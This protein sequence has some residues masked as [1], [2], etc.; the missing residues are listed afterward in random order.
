MNSVPPIREGLFQLLYSVIET[1]VCRV[2]TSKSRQSLESLKTTYVEN[3]PEYHQLVF[4]SGR[5]QN[6][7]D[8]TNALVKSGV[9]QFSAIE[10][11]QQFI[12]NAKLYLI[13]NKG[14]GLTTIW[15]LESADLVSSDM[16]QLLAQLLSWQCFGRSLL[17][18]EL[19]GHSLLVNSYNSGEISKYYRCKIYP[20]SLNENLNLNL[21]N[22]AIKVKLAITLVIGLFLG[23]QID[24]L[25]ARFSNVSN[26]AEQQSSSLISNIKIKKLAPK[27][28]IAKPAF[29]DAGDK[30]S[31][32]EILNQSNI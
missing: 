29:D 28:A 12:E 4:L 23:H 16:H 1:G 3:I 30:N 19:W 10:N 8:L 17:A 13:A 18:V 2:I 20:I 26:A 24:P 15:A 11:H 14:K 9:K 6:L 31:T 21:K 25:L 22:T 32:P 5:I 27:L 7:E